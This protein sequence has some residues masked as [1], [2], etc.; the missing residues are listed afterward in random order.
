MWV[1]KW[2]QLLKFELLWSPQKGNSY[3]QKWLK[4]N[5]V[6]LSSKRLSLDFCS[7][8]LNNRNNKCSLLERNV[9]RSTIKFKH[10]RLIAYFFLI[11][12]N[13][14]NLFFQIYFPNL[15]WANIFFDLICKVI[16]SILL[17]WKPNYFFFVEYRKIWK[18]LYWVDDGQVQKNKF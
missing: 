9:L 8:N 10:L 15:I 13:S 12:S 14:S 2:Q 18:L 16:D 6:L 3:R 7:H 1:S 11:K 5:W 4:P 17:L